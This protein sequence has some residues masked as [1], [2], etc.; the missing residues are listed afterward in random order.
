MRLLFGIL[1][2]L[3]LSGFLQFSHFISQPA[4]MQDLHADDANA[5]YSK[6]SYD[7]RFYKI[8]L[9]VS[10]TSI[11][12][13]GSALIK[14]EVVVQQISHVSLDLVSNYLVDSVLVNDLPAGFQHHS[15]I[16]NIELPEVFFRGQL[17]SLV[18]YYHGRGYDSGE[19]TGIYNRRA[20][21]FGNYTYTLTEPFSAKYFFPCK[22][23]LTDK[24][25]SSHVFITTDSTLKAG[26]NGTLEQIVNL[27]GGKLRYE[28]K[29]R[30][31]IAYYLISMAVG[32]YVDYSFYVYDELHDD[33]ILVMNYIYPEPCLQENKSKI[34]E[35]GRFLLFFSKIFGPYPYADE[36]YGHCLVPLGGG[37]EHQ[38]MTTLGSFSNLLV[39]HE[40]AHQW[41][42]DYVTCSTWQDIWINEGFASY[43]EY[44]SLE[45]LDSEASAMA[46]MENAHH[47]VKDKNTGSIYLPEEDTLNAD[48]I[49][50]YALS[51]KKGAAI[52]HMIRHEVGNDNEFFRILREF[53]ATYQNS[54]SSGEDF[55]NIL[56]LQTGKEFDSFFNQWYYGE[57]FPHF[58]LSWLTRN[59]T[60]IIKSLQET[61]SAATPLFN[62]LM[63][64][65]VHFSDGNDTTITFRQLSNYQEFKEYLPGRIS[66][67]EFDPQKWLL[68]EVD[69]FGHISENGDPGSLFTISPNPVRD[70]LKIWFKEEPGEYSVRIADLSGKI[71]YSAQG[72]NQYTVI[73]FKAYQKSQYILLIL[74]NDNLYAS[75]VV[76]FY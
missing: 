29:T 63:P 6:D 38:T 54:N 39:A 32:N 3:I 19:Q 23:I 68:A 74:I 37:M 55:K 53:L 58:T 72:T 28:W 61:T 76:K 47:Y 35:T 66:G 62:T 4:E 8:D 43:S 21:P 15:D 2:I 64:F 67:L 9:T 14:I 18:V 20:D 11:D 22:Q 57:G 69:R 45:N 44:L 49:F 73:N 71:V 10:D 33:S 70:E 51:Y 65:K 26:S 5:D 50:D 34:D 36:K 52:L 75:K 1:P 16:I 24:A 59:D 56:E 13:S 40:L 46:W 41:F 42:G 48:R 60:L 27:P 17:I 25:D 31:P 7:V 12:I 30:H